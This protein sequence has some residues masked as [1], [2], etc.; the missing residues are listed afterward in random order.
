[1]KV[2]MEGQSNGDKV[3][4]IETEGEPDAL[5]ERQSFP[6]VSPSTS[7]LVTSKKSIYLVVS[8]ILVGLC[9]F[10]IGY[11]VRQVDQT[12]LSLSYDGR[13]V[14]EQHGPN[15]DEYLRSLHIPQY[16]FEMIKSSQELV[17]IQTPLNP[18]TDKWK[19]KFSNEF[20]VHI[21]NFH[22][23]QAFNVT[24]Y[25]DHNYVTYSCSIPSKF[26][27]KCTSQDIKRDWN[28]DSTMIFSPYGYSNY[29]TNI[30]KAVTTSK[31]Y[32]RLKAGE[33]VDL[34]ANTGNVPD[35]NQVDVEYNMEAFE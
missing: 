24:Y 18:N 1:M 26:T 21:L 17:E 13:Y 28:I 20:A 10:M 3:L 12:L 9:I 19:I 27:L 30:N 14:M 15:F 34:E 4:L 31:M 33:T 22:L 5:E 23:D 25:N 32:R 35:K 6:K 29:M 2:S 8:G 7:V 11:E 16:L